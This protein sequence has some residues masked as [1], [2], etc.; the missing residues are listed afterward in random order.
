M[1]AARPEVEDGLALMELG[2]RGR[3]CRSRGTGRG[4]ASSGSSP[5]LLEIE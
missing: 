3:G 4:L 5:A 1:P 2:D